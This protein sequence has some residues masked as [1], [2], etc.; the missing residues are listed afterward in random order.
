MSLTALAEIAK[1]STGPTVTSDQLSLIR[2]TVAKGATDDELKLYLY[3]CA[4]QGVHPLDR[5]VH[6]TKRKEKYTPITSIDFMR[7]RAADSGEYAGNDDPVFADGEKFP[8][9]ATVT[10]YRLVQGQRCAFTATARWKEYKPESNDFMWQRMPHT[11][12]GKCAEALALRK[13]FP[14]Q[15]AGLYAREEMDQAGSESVVTAVAPPPDVN[16]QTGEVVT[17]QVRP[18]PPAGSVY[19]AKVEAAQ[20]RNK[21][22]RKLSLHLSDGRV[23]TTIREQVAAV[24][25][26]C[27]QDNE[28]VIVTV[29]E[30]RWGLD[31]D[32]LKRARM[33]RQEEPV[34]PPHRDD[35]PELT[36][37]DIPF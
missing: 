21:N 31:V 15:L 16:V 35:V 19:I 7:T 27:C 1:T 6:F 3:D 18:E 29:K 9:S 13:G 17:G 11:M 20:T 33:P 26:Q 12:L 22:L 32:T 37:E 10:V 25:E 28:P 34:D 36:D 8:T 30:T 4:R 2:R 23:V 24:A 5:L 14:K